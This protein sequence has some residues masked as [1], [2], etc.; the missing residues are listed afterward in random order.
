MSS[1]GSNGSGSGTIIGSEGSSSEDVQPNSLYGGSA[2]A[3]EDDGVTVSLRSELSPMMD[4]LEEDSSLL[5]NGP[6]A[7]KCVVERS[8]SRRRENYYFMMVQQ[9]SG[10][11]NGGG[12]TVGT[13]SQGE[14]SECDSSSFFGY[15]SRSRYPPPPFVART[16]APASTQTTPMT[17]MRRGSSTSSSVVSVSS[18]SSSSDGSDTDAPV[19]PSLLPRSR[20]SSR[21]A[22]LRSAADLQRE[23]FPHGV[24][25]QGV[26]KSGQQCIAADVKFSAY[27][28]DMW[29]GFI[30]DDVLYMYASG[31][32]GTDRDFRIAVTALVELAEDTLGCFSVL[33]ALPKVL[34]GSLQQCLDPVTAAS[35]VRA[36]MYS[37]FE[38]VSPLLYQPSAS[39]ILVGY[40]TM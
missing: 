29:H 39:Y 40:D 30:I 2:V 6:I 15:G 1:T 13:L 28:K 32:S 38:L 36:F 21:A 27:G 12:S 11:P 16:T 25:S 3:T 5:I 19:A 37:G 17:V 24:A 18:S 20:H 23:I 14:E 4:E 9:H 31:F 33:V 7:A 26:M 34:H 8:S 10:G 35:L 22:A